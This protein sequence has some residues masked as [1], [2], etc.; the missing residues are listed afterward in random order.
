MTFTPCGRFLAAASTRTREL[1]VF[2]TRAETEADAPVFVLPVR[3]VVTGIDTKVSKN[4]EVVSLL[5]VF[6]DAGA[7]IF[8][9]DANYSKAQS[10]GVNLVKLELNITSAQPILAASF[11]S[12]GNR[13][14]AGVVV[15][16][17]RFYSGPLR[18]SY[19]G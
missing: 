15:A 11:G 1:L 18:T 17:F 19:Q 2:D 4:G 12:V 8:E 3:G 7:A 6:E 16:V 14:D 9:L 5:A 10:N 13:D